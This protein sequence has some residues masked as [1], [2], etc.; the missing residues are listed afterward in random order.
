MVIFIAVCALTLHYF[1][2]VRSTLADSQNCPSSKKCSDIRK[3]FWLR[4]FSDLFIFKYI[5]KNIY[6]FPKKEIKNLDIAN[7]ISY[8]YGKSQGEIFVLWVK[9]K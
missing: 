6:G 4:S 8:K 7:D 5:L 9:Q 1:S 3:A 2:T